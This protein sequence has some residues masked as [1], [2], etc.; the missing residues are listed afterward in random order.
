MVKKIIKFQAVR[1]NREES[2]DKSMYE[3]IMY[4]K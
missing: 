3:V 1:V 4:M 2:D